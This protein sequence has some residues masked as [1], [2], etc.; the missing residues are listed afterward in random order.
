M[1]AIATLA[2]N[3]AARRFLSRQGLCKDQRGIAAVEFALISIPLMTML[4]GAFDIGLTLYTKSVLQGALH[5]AARDSS[6][7]LG[8]AQDF[9]DDV[10]EHIR[11][12]I[13]PLGVAE[14]EITISR[15]FYR[16]FTDADAAT[17]EAFTDNNGSGVCDDGEPFSDDN[18]NG[19]WDEDGASEGQGGALDNVILTVTV[20]RDRL[21]PLHVF[22]G[23]P[24][25]IT[26][27]GTT[28]LSNQPYG[29]QNA[30]PGAIQGQCL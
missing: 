8:T 16:S 19:D 29:E 22:V 11:A 14:E 7:E 10:D 18:R 15:R 25:R 13:M 23:G 5:A 24:E 6:L 17:P 27:S 4:M 12:Q 9:R 3:R 26:F 30:A 21:F 28:V 1:R 2:A 20:E